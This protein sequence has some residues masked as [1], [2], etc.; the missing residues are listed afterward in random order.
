M[1]SH[2]CLGHLS[3]NKGILFLKWRV[4]DTKLVFNLD[5]L[6]E[7]LDIEVTLSKFMVLHL[8]GPEAH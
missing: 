3:F 8:L 1:T 5:N 2:V 7:F 6:S 4:K